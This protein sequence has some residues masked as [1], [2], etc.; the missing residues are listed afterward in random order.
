MTGIY[1]GMEADD[2]SVKGSVEVT[3]IYDKGGS[4]LPLNTILEEPCRN[5]LIVPSL[6]APYPL[7]DNLVVDLGRG[8]IAR[9]LG[10]Q[11]DLSQ[12]VIS[13]VSFGVGSEPPRYNDATL[14]PQ[15][16]GIYNGGENQIALLP[17][18]FKKSFTG[19][20][21][22]GAHL[23]RYSFSIDYSEGNGNV[24]REAA[25]W[26]TGD[27]MFARKTFPGIM[28]SG[29]QRIEMAWTIRC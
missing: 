19:I 1:L 21:F 15:R 4:P 7:G 22:P 6:A 10:G 18:I 29:D 20:D 25:L 11:G 17:G 5:G 28:K 14:S 2:I 12:D 27:T 16:G 23:V 13:K 3:G 24:V 26:T 9:L 8:I